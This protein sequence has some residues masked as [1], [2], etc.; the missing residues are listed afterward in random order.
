MDLEERDLKMFLVMRVGVG[1]VQ[2][3]GRYAV[4]LWLCAGGEM[5][6]SAVRRVSC[7]V[8]DCAA[9]RSVAVEMRAEGW[10]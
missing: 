8:V 7:A 5:V 1:Y 9:V 10:R 2:S 4:L 6:W 3:R